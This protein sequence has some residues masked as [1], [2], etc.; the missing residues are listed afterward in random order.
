MSSLI[1]TAGSVVRPISLTAV[2]TAVSIAVSLAIRLKIVGGSIQKRLQ[3]TSTGR[4]R[5]Q[6]LLLNG[7]T[8]LLHE[9]K[10]KGRRGNREG[11]LSGLRCWK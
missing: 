11:L 9:R 7:K 8:L 1:L 2:S 4:R 10:R 5:I 6:L 3:S